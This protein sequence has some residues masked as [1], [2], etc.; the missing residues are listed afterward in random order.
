[1]RERTRWI[2]RASRGRLE[3]PLS[4]REVRGKAASGGAGAGAPLVGCEGCEGCWDCVGGLN[5][6]AFVVAGGVEMP[7]AIISAAGDAM[8]AVW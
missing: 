6:G 5:V 2:R 1:M 8:V 7:L 3:L 4:W